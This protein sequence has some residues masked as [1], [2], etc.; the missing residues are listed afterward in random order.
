[1]DAAW[2][3][4]ASIVIAMISGLGAWFALKRKGGG[5]VKT[6][7]ASE[8][9]T[10]NAEFRTMLLTEARERSQENTSLRDEMAECHRERDL[11]ESRVTTLEREIAR[12]KRGR[13]GQ[14]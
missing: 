11:L 7:E 6:S 10:A 14:Q 8:L 9:W 3:P 4:L 1:M 12:L 5:T 2:A 13:G